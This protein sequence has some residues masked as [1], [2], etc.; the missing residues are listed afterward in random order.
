VAAKRAGISVVALTGLTGAL[1][2]ALVWRAALLLQA[3]STV[4]R[5]L[6]L[7]V[8]ILPL[9]VLWGVWHEVQFGRAAARLGDQLA[10]SGGLPKDRL[11]RRPSGRIN[12]KAADLA[13]EKFSAEAQKTPDSWPVQFRLGLAYD[14]C[15]DRRRARAAMR[16]AIRL[17]TAG[18]D[19]PAGE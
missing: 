2:L 15:G 11:P 9:L 3:D 18:A 7:G 4:A 17:A 12:R 10:V 14:A 16:R 8:I 1:C 13:F 19:R 5:L 6:G